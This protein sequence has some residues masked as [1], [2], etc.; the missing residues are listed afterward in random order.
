MVFK[1]SLDRLAKGVSIAILLLFLGIG[2]SIIYNLD[3][4]NPN[5]I[6]LWAAFLIESIFIGILLFCYLYAPQ[7]YMIESDKIKIIRPIGKIEITLSNIS[8]IRIIEKSELKT[9]IR[10]FSVGGLFGYFGYYYS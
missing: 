7:A 6:P 8:N 4:T 9:L 1:A 3:P 2:A 10:T 5:E